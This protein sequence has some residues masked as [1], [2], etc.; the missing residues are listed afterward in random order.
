MDAHAATTSETQ[1]FD[2]RQ[3]GILSERQARVL[4]QRHEELARALGDRLTLW[5]RSDFGLRLARVE[6]VSYASFIAGLP[7]TTH[8]TLFKLEPLRGVCLLETP[9]PLATAV[10]ER[11][12]GGP[13]ERL[14]ETRELTEVEIALFDQWA[15]VF[16][17]EWQRHFPEPPAPKP[18]LLGHES[19]PRF[20]QSAPPDTM[21]V[22]V[23]FEAA[24]ADG[25]VPVQ[26]AFPYPTL[27][28]LLRQIAPAEEPAAATA[29]ASPSAPSVPWNNVLDDMKLSVSAHWT[30]LEMTA[31]ELAALKVGDVIQLAPQIAAQV[32]VRLAGRAK[33]SG[34]LGTCGGQWAV[35]LTGPDTTK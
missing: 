18:H 17:E 15:Q 20:L 2:F 7:A 6:A 23:I 25:K 30:G 4:R 28:P 9:P 29:P 22:E 12:L 34:R 14:G 33:F 13:G 1:P 32:R 8:L 3:G 21:M 26:L 16:L 35:E 19:A 27:E 5:L 31:R 11:L 10:V 24:F